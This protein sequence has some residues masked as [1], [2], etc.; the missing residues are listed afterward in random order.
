MDMRNIGEFLR[1]VPDEIT[2]G[3]GHDK[4]AEWRT[5][6]DEHSEGVHQ[7]HSIQVVKMDNGLVQ[8]KGALNP[9]GAGEEYCQGQVLP[10][11]HAEIGRWR[12]HVG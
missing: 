10:L 12:E 9:S 1:H 4:I 6:Q 3:G 7:R 5:F 2:P 8:K 11:P